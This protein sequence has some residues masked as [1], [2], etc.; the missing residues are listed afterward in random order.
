LAAETPA[1]ARGTAIDALRDKF[2]R[3]AVVRGLALRP[4]T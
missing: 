1:K 3:A 4:K 2:G